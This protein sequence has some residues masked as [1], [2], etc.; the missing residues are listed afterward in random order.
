MAHSTPDQVENFG[1][2]W[3]VTTAAGA[4]VIALVTD[5]RI[6]AQYLRWR[7]AREVVEGRLEAIGQ[8]AD[9]ESV[10]HSMNTYIA[11]ERAATERLIREQLPSIPGPWVFWLAPALVEAFLTRRHNERH[12]DDERQFKIP[13]ERPALPGRKPRNNGDDIVR[14]VNW[15][16]RATVKLPADSVTALGDEYA[17]TVRRNNDARSV[18]QN[19]IDQA[20]SLLDVVSTHV[21]IEPSL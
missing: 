16:Y 7:A 19:G 1:D 4:F 17:A 10:R 3:R 8:G 5:F 20:R 13:V 18:I 15:F 9:L 11:T 6:D 14:N 12:P 21:T 2:A